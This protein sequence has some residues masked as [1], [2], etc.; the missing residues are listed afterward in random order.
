MCR[1]HL[2]ACGAAHLQ[3]TL[4]PTPPVKLKRRKYSSRPRPGFR[5][6]IRTAHVLGGKHENV[7]TLLS[8]R[9]DTLY[10]SGT[11]PRPRLEAY[12]DCRWGSTRRQW[13]SV[14]CVHLGWG[15]LTGREPRE[16]SP[17]SLRWDG[18]GSV[19]TGLK[20]RSASFASQFSFSWQ[21]I[22]FK[23]HSCNVSSSITH[24]VVLSIGAVESWPW[25]LSFPSWT[26][27]GHRCVR[28]GV[29]ACGPATRPV[30]APHWAERAL[31]SPTFPPSML[32]SSEVSKT[33]WTAQGRLE[34]ERLKP[35]CILMKTFR[36]QAYLTIGH[37]EQGGPLWSLRRTCMAHS[38]LQCFGRV[39]CLHC[40]HQV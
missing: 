7:G 18:P 40:T 39:P 5:A 32:S 6:P 33:N 4:D 19:P 35:P 10:H 27:Q 30:A 2:I 23:K 29:G 11:R 36:F 26:H 24:C 21:W 9:N 13:M 38:R 15:C 28:D 14:W 16:V 1:L 34:W 31:W 20:K 22:I 37:H 8:H 17:G 25:C 3:T 12:L